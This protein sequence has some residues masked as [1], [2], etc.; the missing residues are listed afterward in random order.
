VIDVGDDR[1]VANAGE[2]GHGLT[3]GVA[4]CV[5]SVATHTAP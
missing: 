2:L 1:E 4:L 5:P 3:D